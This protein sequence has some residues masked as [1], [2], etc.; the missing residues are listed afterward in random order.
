MKFRRFLFLFSAVFAMV[1]MLVS[2]TSY[3]R[4][5]FTIP[6]ALAPQQEIATTIV[7]VT[8]IKEG[9]TLKIKF[10]GDTGK[11]ENIEVNG[12]EKDCDDPKFVF[13]L[14]ETY[15]CIRP[16]DEHPANTDINND[17]K[18]DVYC[19][20]VLFLTNGAD[21]RFK[22]DSAAGNKTCKN[23]GGSVVCY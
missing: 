18:Q 22:A 2:C 11:C 8:S 3:K 10:N 4:T 1:A 14:K 6:S 23:V 13:P 17:G 16:D 19:G 9:G 21:I 7:E 5:T 20:E 15:Y 12:K